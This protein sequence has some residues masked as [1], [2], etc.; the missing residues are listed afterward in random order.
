MEHAAL[1]SDLAEG[2]S[3]GD[4]YWIET[5]DGLRL[6][7]GLWRKETASSG[8]VFLFPGRTEYVEIYGRTATELDELGFSTF[9]IDW[10]GQGLSDRQTADR[11]AGHVNDF[12]DFQKDVAAM[13][14]AAQELDLPK[15]WFLLGHSMGACIGTRALIEGLPVEACGFSAPM[16]D[17]HLSKVERMGAWPLTWAAKAFGKAHNYAPGYSGKSY[18]LS[19][20][21]SDNRLT[22]DPDMYR[23]WTKQALS[24]SDLLIGGPTMGWLFQALKETKALSGMKSPDI[25]CIAFGGSEDAIVDLLAI[26]NRMTRWPNSKFECIEGAKHELLAEKPATRADMLKKIADLFKSIEKAA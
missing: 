2:P 15:P 9:V 25:P 20:D 6:R 18:V 24:Q 23:Y 26:K 1:Y 4:A 11:M 8:T 21:F 7:V 13:V 10:R 16:F 19:N 3:K 17:I 22:N 12:K 14:E 5:E